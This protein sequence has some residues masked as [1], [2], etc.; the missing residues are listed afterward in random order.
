VQANGEGQA[1]GSVGLQIVEQKLSNVSSSIR[2]VPE[3]QSLGPEQGVAPIGTH[4][5]S[6]NSEASSENATAPQA[7]P[8][9]QSAVVAHR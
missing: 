8:D 7:E 5:N 1:F 2:Q 9:G 3:R 4:T 6:E